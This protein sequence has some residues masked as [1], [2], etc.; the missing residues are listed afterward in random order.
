[1]KVLWIFHEK[2]ASSYRKLGKG[3]FFNRNFYILS[4]WS[5]IIIKNLFQCIAFSGTSTLET[6]C[7]YLQ[8]VLSDSDL[9]HAVRSLNVQL[10]RE[11]E[12]YENTVDI[13]RGITVL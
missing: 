3:L 4:R 6:V 7:I 12:L 11:R 1:M 2:K 8:Q 9:I 5:E 13:L 10:S